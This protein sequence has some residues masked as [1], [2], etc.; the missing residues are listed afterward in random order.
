MET[1]PVDRGALADR[2][3]AGTLTHDEAC[4]MWEALG[5]RA[6]RARFEKFDLFEAWAQLCIDATMKVVTGDDEAQRAALG[7]LVRGDVQD[8]AARFEAIIDSGTAA[9]SRLLNRKAGL[10]IFVDPSIAAD[11]LVRSSALEPEDRALHWM[12]GCLYESEG[13]LERAEASLCRAYELEVRAGETGD[14]AQSMVKLAAVAE[15]RKDGALA[16]ER[17]R[18]AAGLYERAADDAGAAEVLKRLG[19]DEFA[20]D[21]FESAE[22]DYARALGHYEKLEPGLAMADLLEGLCLLAFRRE[23]WDLLLD[24]A[25]RRRDLARTLNERPDQADA[26]FDIGAACRGLQRPAEAAEGYSR[27]IELYAAEGDLAWQAESLEALARLLEHEDK[28]ADAFEALQQAAALH[29]KAGAEEKLG[30]VR[31]RMAD[32]KRQ[33]PR[34]PPPPSQYQPNTREYFFD[35]VVYHFLTDADAGAM[36]EFITRQARAGKPAPAGAAEADDN[37]T[38]TDF[39][40]VVREINARED[41]SEGAVLGLLVEG[42]I[43]KAAQIF[44]KVIGSAADRTQEAL[45]TKGALFVTVAPA[46]S[47]DAW[48]RLLAIAPDF[49]YGRC[50]YGRLLA[51]LGELDAAEAAFREVLARA[52]GDAASQA[53]ATDW[54]G[55]LAAQRGDTDAE[56]SYIERSLQLYR[57]A[58]DA[59]G[60]RRTLAVLGVMAGKR[61]ERIMAERYFQEALAQSEQANDTTLARTLLEALAG[62]ATLR[63][64]A[65]AAAAL[66][67]RLAELPTD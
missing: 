66:Q 51:R 49:H 2:I 23:A 4:S 40:E 42:S 29:E 3:V 48:E 56:W 30:E 7:V 14:A 37:R 25:T 19:D 60:E 35:R 13:D 26:W 5:D 43:E 10:F 58:G 59:D 55:E 8:A 61:G 64:D 9:P 32:L 46:T 53:S 62:F 34:P 18:E 16:I 45:W 36:L 44:E 31:K 54:L 33:L 67:A 57:G 41:P 12:L 6:T 28:P 52:D 27:A 21:E 20:R 50:A 11:A 38:L 24:W 65:A 17:R 39:V 63:G 1:S 15:A 47:R 22:S